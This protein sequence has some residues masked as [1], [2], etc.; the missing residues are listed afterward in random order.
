MLFYERRQRQVTGLTNGEDQ[1]EVYL[2]R[3]GA[4]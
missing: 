1:E 3:W 2:R 4:F